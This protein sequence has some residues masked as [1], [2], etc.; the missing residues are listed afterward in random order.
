MT[1][2]DKWTVK[3]LNATTGEV[4]HLLGPEGLPRL[5][6]EGV[7]KAVHSKLDPKRYRVEMVRT[8]HHVKGK[9]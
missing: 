1:R 9:V 2:D 8:S 4:E 3:I 7:E 6:A 5:T